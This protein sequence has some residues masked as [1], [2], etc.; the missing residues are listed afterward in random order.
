MFVAIALGFAL[1]IAPILDAGKDIK[2]TGKHARLEAFLH[3]LTQTL[4]VAGSAVLAGTTS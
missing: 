3:Q 1:T 2:P 4:G